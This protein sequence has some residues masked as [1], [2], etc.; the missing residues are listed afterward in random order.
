[1]PA[2]VG[3]LVVMAIA[4][5]IDVMKPTALAFVAPGMAL[6]YGLK[7]LLNPTAG[8][9]RLPYLPLSGIGRRCWAHS[10]GVG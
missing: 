6:E 4:V 10:C 5:T 9:C 1:M 3:L 7:S 8:L 2:H